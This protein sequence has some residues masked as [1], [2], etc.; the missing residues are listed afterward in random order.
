M[1]VWFWAGR[2]EPFLL[3]VEMVKGSWELEAPGLEAERKFNELKTCKLFATFYEC[4]V[5]YSKE[6]FKALE[7]AWGR[8]LLKELLLNK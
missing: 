6:W 3:P 2:V 8:K 4:L 5:F 7:A 1:E